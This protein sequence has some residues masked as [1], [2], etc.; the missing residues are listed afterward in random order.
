MKHSPFPNFVT[1]F[2]ALLKALILLTA[3][4][5]VLLAAGVDPARALIMVNT[6]GLTGQGRERLAYPSDF[7]NGQ[8][9]VEALLAAHTIS[10]PPGTDEYRI[11]LL[12]ESGVAGW[13]LPDEDTLAAQLTA[14][15]FAIDEREVMVYNLAYPQPSVARDIL[16]LDAVLNDDPAVAPNLVIWFITP[17]ALDNSEQ[18]IGAN[19]VF[20]NIN[21]ERFLRLGAENRALVGGWYDARAPRLLD[22]PPVWEPYIALRGQTLLPIWAGS[23]LYPFEEPDLGV[24]DRRMIREPLPETARYM[25]DHPGFTELPNETWAFLD[26]GCRIAAARGTALIF[27]NEPMFI[28][29][30]LNSDRV[31]NLQY[32]R[33]L[34]DRYREALHTYAAD[35]EIGMIDLWDIIPPP[36]FTDT[37]LHID[38][39]GFA[40]LAGVLEDA[41]T[42]AD[43]KPGCHIAN[44][45][46]D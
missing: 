32:G 4:N 28:G 29:E 10:Q 36:H 6:W 33:D 40:L 15:E 45:P 38:A 8:L 41:L 37:P 26:V 2:R 16:I 22:D 20:F 9:P 31:Y 46:L 12:G 17:S 1:F 7:S 19:R 34:Y 43:L 21:R 35:Q 30:G 42:D 3:L 14:L 24:T 11:A 39:D 44:A 25:D 23:L 27:A 18:I 5:I 13:G